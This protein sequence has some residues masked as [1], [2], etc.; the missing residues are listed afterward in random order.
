M[1]LLWTLLLMA[2]VWASPTDPSVHTPTPVAVETPALPAGPDRGPPPAG[3]THPAPE[4]GAQPPMPPFQI[5]GGVARRLL[6]G[7]ALVWLLQ[8]GVSR[9]RRRLPPGLR[10]DLLLVELGGVALGVG[11]T[12][13]LVLHWLHRAS[14]SLAGWALAALALTLLV[15]LGRTL[16]RYFEGLWLLLGPGV[17]LGDQLSVND[18]SGRLV[19]V[20][21][22]RLTLE[23]EAGRRISI[24]VMALGGAVITL[25]KRA[26]SVPFQLR[27]SL[28]PAQD[29]PELARALRTA[30]QMS[31]FRDPAGPVEIH[32]DDP[33]GSLE[34]SLLLWSTELSELA[35]RQLRQVAQ[36]D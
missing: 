21:L 36:T 10:D 1:S 32:L 7:G 28:D 3:P 16:P 19:Q 15:V 33:G 31:P 20:G 30:A 8:L 24:P 34:V 27:L 22:L 12:L 9:V 11:G 23:D 25:V 5:A 35:D 18:Q 29:G 26:R 2:S 13:W 17:Q 14:P 6:L 4:P